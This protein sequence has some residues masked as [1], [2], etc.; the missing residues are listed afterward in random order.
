M[1][2]PPTQAVL[3]ELPK[4]WEAATH[5]HKLRGRLPSAVRRIAEE[6]AIDAIL[7]RARQI[8]RHASRPTHRVND[9]FP[10]DGELDLEATLEQPRPWLPTDIIL[11]RVDPREA[12]VVLILD[13]SLSMTGEKIAL[14]AVAAAIMKIKLESVAVVQFDTTA[15]TL[16]R[17]GESVPV[18]ELV[19]RILTVPAQG[20]TNIEAGLEEGLTVLRRARKPERVGVILTDGIANMGWDPVRVAVR[21][22]R[23]H[24][25][26]LGN[27][28]R[29]GGA[30]C[31]RMA[32]SGRGRRFETV[33]YAQLPE[34]M[35]KLIRDCFEH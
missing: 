15:H 34:V 23:L 16:V 4:D 1:A 21:Y 31:R 30:T 10:A 14:T 28:D 26:Q 18:R 32:R 33:I 20:Y 12:D 19:R 27:R 7:D 22:P 8:L 17:V 6:R 25:V 13:M 29:H 9:H 11:E 35:R 5:F 3:D 24:V 2:A